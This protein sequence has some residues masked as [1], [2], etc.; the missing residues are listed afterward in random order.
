VRFDQPASLFTLIARHSKRAERSFPM[1]QSPRFDRCAVAML[2]ALAFAATAFGAQGGADS[3]EA[4]FASVRTAMAEGDVAGILAQ[5]APSQRQGAALELFVGASFMIAFNDNSEALEK[6][7]EKILDKHGLET[8]AD[9]PGV[10]P[11]TDEAETQQ[12]A[13]KLFNGKDEVAFIR[14]LFGF[15]AD[16]AD[17]DLKQTI[18]DSEKLADLKIDGDRAT[19]TWTG[20]PVLMLR[21]GGRWYLDKAFNSAG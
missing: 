4:V 19:A 3:P 15:L 18:D 21:E 8:L 14:D 13:E 2:T 6:G 16:N 10:G 12:I 5:V 17:L 9:D 1:Q 7:L 11:E 20:K